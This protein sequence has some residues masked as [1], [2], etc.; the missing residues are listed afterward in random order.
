VKFLIL[1]T[2]ILGITGLSGTAKQ[3]LEPH[4][5]GATE[6]RNCC[7]SADGLIQPCPAQNY[8]IENPTRNPVVVELS[9]GSDL[10]GPTFTIPPHTHQRVEVCPEIP[11]KLN[12]FILRWEKK[13]W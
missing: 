9:C 8:T 10:I 5:S 2:M 1:T 6:G 11:V 7:E 3:K 4:I 13:S 12:C